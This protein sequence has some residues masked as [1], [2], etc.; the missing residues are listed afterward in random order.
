MVLSFLVSII[1]TKMSNSYIAIYV[2]TYLQV[3][4]KNVKASD[5]LL[6]HIHSICYSFKIEVI[7]TTDT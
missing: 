5:S 4:F 3:A 6:I 2:R 7:H 1:A